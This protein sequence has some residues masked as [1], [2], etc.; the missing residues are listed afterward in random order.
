MPTLVLSLIYHTKY[1]CIK[2]IVIKK[3]IAFFSIDAKLNKKTNKYTYLHFK[4]ISKVKNLGYVI[5]IG[6]EGINRNLLLHYLP[7]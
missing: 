7:L 4:K 2:N 3:H 6:T 5:R 1:Y